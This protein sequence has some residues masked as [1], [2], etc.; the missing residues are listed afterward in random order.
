MIRL[1][2]FPT[3]GLLCSCTVSADIDKPKSN[4]ISLYYSFKTCEYSGECETSLPSNKL[5]EYIFRRLEPAHDEFYLKKDK[6]EYYIYYKNIYNE[7]VQVGWAKSKLIK[8]DNSNLI[9]NINKIN[10]SLGGIDYLKN[11][12]SN[13]EA[14]SN[15]YKLG[16]YNLSENYEGSPYYQNQ[17]INFKKINDNLLLDCKIYM[18]N[19]S[20]KDGLT[21]IFYGVCSDNKK[22]YFKVIEVK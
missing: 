10:L 18:N 8:S 4:D 3:I 6:N 12:Y 16:F 22:V 19:S 2:I 13:R 9:L 14:K 1:Y 7:D 17:N 21:G 15:N 11:G 20:V 5:G